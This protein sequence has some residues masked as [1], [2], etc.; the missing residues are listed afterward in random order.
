V[1]ARSAAASPPAPAQTP[2]GEP[3]AA[4]DPAPAKAAGNGTVDLSAVVGMEAEAY[5][6]AR[7][8]SLRGAPG[9]PLPLVLD[10][11]A[12]AGLP[13]AAGRRVYRLL[14][15]LAGSMQVVVLGD[16]DAISTWAEGLGDRAAVRQVAR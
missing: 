15:R 14:G 11:E 9:G 12:V 3:E 4:P 2:E 6:L 10:G 16:D 7:V 1:R 13:E 8:A 5:L